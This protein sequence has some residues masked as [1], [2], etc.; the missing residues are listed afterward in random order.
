MIEVLV[1]DDELPAL[2]ELDYLLRRDPRVG[3]VRC[4][5]TG[6]AALRVLQES[7][8]D[9]VLLDIHMPGLSGLELAGVLQRFV[10]PP[11]VAFVTADASHAVQAYDLAAVDY[12][13][14]P[15]R[16][17]RL[18]EAIRRVVEA[19]PAQYGSKQSGA[20]QPGAMDVGANRV[21]AQQAG[22]NSAGANS[23]GANQPTP[24][25]GA[26][27]SGSDPGG[28]GPASGAPTPASGAGPAA[29]EAST[30]VEVGDASVRIR[31]SEITHV[32]A[33]GDYARLHTGHGSYLER[34]TLGE[35]ERRWAEA[36]FVRIHRSAL[37]RISAVTRVHR[38]GGAPHVRVAG[39]DLPV[40]RRALTRV[41][42]ALRRDADGGQ[43]A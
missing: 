30:V 18:A 5:Q 29:S 23:A 16:P 11:S 26:A 37:V 43:G 24:G 1:V 9:L 34:V 27:R 25:Q 19:E 38:V 13:L 15:V 8:P 22:T 35:L 28:A 20:D 41:R 33:A 14:K 21:G 12:L 31:L 39:T 10:T 32:T 7:R 4:A 42:E 6:A 36:G 2:R 3:E 40:A 17:A